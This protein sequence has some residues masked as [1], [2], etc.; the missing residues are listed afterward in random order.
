MFK[1]NDGI[2]S[3]MAEYLSFASI[4]SRFFHGPHPTFIKKH[5]MNKNWPYDRFIAI[6]C[7]DDTIT[8]CFVILV[9]RSQSRIDLVHVKDSIHNLISS[10]GKDGVRIRN[11]LLCQVNNN[12]I[13]ITGTNTFPLDGVDRN[14]VGESPRFVFKMN[15]NHVRIYYTREKIL[16]LVFII[17]AAVIFEM[18]LSINESKKICMVDELILFR[19]MIGTI[20]NS[21]INIKYAQM[22][23]SAL[24]IRDVMNK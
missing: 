17:I 3:I 4:D 20:M 11:E 23:I 24:H 7:M 22:I 15:T 2:L 8:S 10:T 13:E 1:T 18:S 9:S 19:S 14:E 12:I 6:D 16:N 5:C 21:D